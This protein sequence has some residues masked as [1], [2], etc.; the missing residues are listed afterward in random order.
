MLEFKL[1]MLEKGATV[2]EYAYHH[3]IDLGHP[4]QVM[5]CLIFV[6]VHN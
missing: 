3:V 1:T 6:T 2:S 4:W 5:V